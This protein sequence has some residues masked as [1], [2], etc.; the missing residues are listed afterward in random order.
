MTAQWPLSDKMHRNRF[1]SGCLHVH[2]QPA[3]LLRSWPCRGRRCGELLRHTPHGFAFFPALTLCESGQ[4]KQDELLSAVQCIDVLSFEIHARRW[5][6]FLELFNC[7]NTI[8]DAARK[9]GNSLGENQVDLPGPAITDHLVEFRTPSPTE[10]PHLHR[11][12]RASNWVAVVYI[13]QC[14]YAAIHSCSF[15]LRQAWIRGNMHRHASVVSVS[16]LPHKSDWGNNQDA[17]VWVG[18]IFAPDTGL[19]LGVAHTLHSAHPNGSLMVTPTSPCSAAGSHRA[20]DT[21][22]LYHTTQRACPARQSLR[23]PSR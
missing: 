4:N 21:A 17:L 8:P 7:I 1:L 19:I 13:L 10:F 12:P 14:N 5:V 23:F 22:R 9:P 11:Y 2:A 18:C 3:A 6:E 20:D 15:E 16:D